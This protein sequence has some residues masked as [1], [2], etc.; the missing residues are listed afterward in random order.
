MA[1]A[2][3]ELAEC[4]VAF[5]SPSKVVFTREWATD[6]EQQKEN[7]IRPKEEARLQKQIEKAQEGEEKVNNVN[8]ITRENKDRETRKE[9]LEK[10][11]KIQQKEHKNH[12]NYWGSFLAKAP[13]ENC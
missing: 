4:E 11:E 5:F 1:C 2:K 12:M 3:E 13:K 10:Q 6:Q 7:E 8:R 9:V